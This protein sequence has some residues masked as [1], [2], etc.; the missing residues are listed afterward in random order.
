MF[1]IQ[2][3]TLCFVYGKR[4]PF[5]CSCLPILQF[6]Q[7]LEIVAG[8]PPH[9]KYIVFGLWPQKPGSIIG[10]GPVGLQHRHIG[11][12]KVCSPLV[13]RT[14]PKVLAVGSLHA[15]DSLQCNRFLARSR[16]QKYDIILH[17]QKAP[18]NPP[19]QASRATPIAELQFFTFLLVQAHLISGVVEGGRSCKTTGNGVWVYFFSSR[20]S[21]QALPV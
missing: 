19:S 18:K 8:T 5:P 15:R 9:V 17:P 13:L 14:Q 3:F 21:S 4:F 16:E 1:G 12:T 20:Y 11:P 2:L 7:D 10:T 6:H